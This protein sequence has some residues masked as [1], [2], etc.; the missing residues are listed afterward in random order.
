MFL[1][2]FQYRWMATITE[3]LFFWQTWTGW[4]LFHWAWSYLNGVAIASSRCES[5]DALSVSKLHGTITRSGVALGPLPPIWPACHSST[6]TTRIR[7]CCCGCCWGCCTDVQFA[8]WLLFPG[9]LVHPCYSAS[10]LSV[11][12]NCD[13]LHALGFLWKATWQN[14]WDFAAIVFVGN[15]HLALLVS[16]LPAFHRTKIDGLFKKWRWWWLGGFLDRNLDLTE[17]LLLP[18]VLEGS[19]D[20]ASTFGDKR[21][22]NTFCTLRF[23]GGALRHGPSDLAA[24]TL[25]GQ[26]H[27]ALEIY[28]STFHLANVDRLLHSLGERGGN[29]K[30]KS[31]AKE[32]PHLF[33]DLGRKYSYVAGHWVTD[34]WSRWKGSVFQSPCL[35]IVQVSITF[36]SQEEASKHL[37]RYMIQLPKKCT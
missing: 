19:T 2:C 21:D 18:S 4:I 16:H 11:K 28:F 27:G 36:E 30:E 9:V 32:P 22:L 24:V 33:R 23:L 3:I 15:H 34:R 17:S 7:G 14:L 35:F 1:W 5:I 37:N 12:W 29:Q 20:G 10:L 25:E 31:K 13:T 26:L 8:H 6:R